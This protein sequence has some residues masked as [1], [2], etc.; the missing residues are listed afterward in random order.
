MSITET[1]EKYKDAIAVIIVN[2]DQPEITDRLVEQI[3]DMKISFGISNPTTSIDI[4][5]IE[6]GSK[7]KRSKY[8]S[9]WY[10]DEPFSGKCYGHVRG[11]EYANEQGSYKYYWFM[12]ND[13]VY[14]PKGNNPIETLY[15]VMEN[16]PSIGILSPTEP[17]GS[18]PDCQ[19]WE[20]G[21][22]HIVAT[23]D[24]L[25]LFVSG[26][27]IRDIGFLNSEFKYSWGAIHELSYKAYSSGWKIAYCDHVTMKHLGGT[28]YGQVE[29]IP[30]REEY[31]SRAKSFAANY[32]F[33]KYGHDWDVKFWDAVKLKGA[34]HNT[35]HS[36]KIIFNE[37]LATPHRAS[38]LDPWF[39]PVT[40][41]DY[42]VTPGIGSEFSPEYLSNRI[43]HRQTLIVDEFTARYDL[44]D[45]SVL[46]LACN[47]GYWSSQ[48]VKH[49]AS[50]VLGIE[51]REKYFRQAKLYWSEN[52]FTSHRHFIRADVEKESTWMKIEGEF[53]VTICAGILYHIH[54][55]EALL[56]W[57][58]KITKDVIVIDT[59]VGPPEEKLIKEPGDHDFNAI[60]EYMKRVPN[61]DKMIDLLNELGFRPEKLVPNFGPTLGLVEG[62]NY[63]DGS[64]VTILAWRPHCEPGTTENRGRKS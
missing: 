54:N 58:A 2:R 17:N 31:Q 23:V 47:C 7:G 36:S 48:Y 30:T 6:M 56:T 52:D 18:Y 16:D 55:Y 25:S 1:V 32:F 27:M 19:P 15:N 14:N 46:E 51:G 34:R 4:F 42:Q 11:L 22:Y 63:A 53:D 40:L 44:K 49:G 57:L 38:L 45:K 21:D 64:R 28:T 3:K 29:G 12:M 10:E 20:K 24:Y 43:K 9:L 39:Y 5:V 50:Y 35:F 13:L 60:G 8:S 26:K 61:F 37:E 59:R 41:K 33:E 62:D